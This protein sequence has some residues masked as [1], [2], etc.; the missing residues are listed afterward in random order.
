MRNGSDPGRRKWSAGTKFMLALLAVVV[1]GSALVLGRLSAG[2]SVDLTKLNMNVLDIA[3]DP[4][5]IAADETEDMPETK[6]QAKKTAAPAAQPTA[7]PKTADGFTLTFGGTISLSGEVRKNSKGT[8]SGRPDYADIMMLLEQRINSDVN[9][10]FLENI[11]SDSLKANDNVAPSSATVVLKEAGFGMAACGWSQAY[12]SGKDGV[13]DTLATLGVDG[14]TALGL[15]SAED[16]G[17]P[18]LKT[19]KGIRTAF[20]QYTSTVPAKTRKAMEKEGTSGMVPEAEIGLITEDIAAAR[21]AGAEA[22]I[23]LVSWGKAGKDPDK[24]QRELAAGI[25][26][27]GAD[28]IIGN[29][30]RVPQ[31]AEYLAG[32]DGRSV[33]C[34]WSLG[35]LLSGD[36]SNTKRMSG[37]LFHV[38]VRSD[39]DGG[40]QVL[41]PEYTPVYTWKYRQDGRYYYRV[42]AT[43]REAPDG[44]DSEQLKAMQKSAEAVANVLKDSPLTERGQSDAD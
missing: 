11:V 24:A 32:K 16:S 15:R 35:T 36:R 25:A 41:N 1:A 21:K 10:A 28:L 30:S 29:G 22:V 38:T 17:A 20:L 33:L 8:D 19:I 14:I 37:Y 4:A 13:E 44:M 3:E 2:A 40:A 23:V 27:A 9:G 18:V 34:V 6:P 31:T 43:D 26:Q 42:I 39:G 5:H 7:E 12:V